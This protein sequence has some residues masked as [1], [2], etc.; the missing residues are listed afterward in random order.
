MDGFR[1]VHNLDTGAVY[2]FGYA[3]S[4]YQAMKSLIYSLNLRKK[5]PNAK[6][7][8]CGHFLTVVHNGETWTTK[9]D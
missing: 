6:I 2:T 3:P 5:D 8:K 1:E 7:E 4:A 9:D